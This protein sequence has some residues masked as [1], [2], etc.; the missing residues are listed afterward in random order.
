[1]AETVKSSGGLFGLARRAWNE[2]A[3]I[4]RQKIWQISLEQD[5]GPRA[6]WYALLRV[7][8]ITLTGLG[9]I[10]IFSRAAA[11]SYSS[12]LGIGPMIAIAVMAAGTVLHETPTATIIEKINQGLR[13][14]AP[15][16]DQMSAGAEAAEQAEKTSQLAINQRLI[17]LL[18]TFVE[19]SR[20]KAIGT[21]GL[22]M[23]IV[24]VVQLFISIEESFNTIW[25]VR[26]GRSM[27]TRIVMYWTL[28]TLGAV[29]ALVAF[30]IVSSAITPPV[31]DDKA[32]V[33]PSTLTGAQPDATT[34][35]SAPVGATPRSEPK[36]ATPARPAISP[37][38]NPA[39]DVKENSDA[40]NT[41]ALK[42]V[43]PSILFLVLVGLLTFFYRFIPNTNVR[44]FPSLI[45]AAVVA[46]LL[47]ANNYL[48][49]FYVRGVL[50]AQSLFGSL[51]LPVVLMGGL[52]IFWL[53]VLLGGQITYAVQNVHY[54]SSRT[55]WEE[56]NQHSREGLSLLVLVLI[57]RR[58]K[59]T[60]APFT[61][62][63]LSTSMRVPAQVLNESINRLVDLGYVSTIPPTT[64][65]GSQDYRYQPARPLDQITLREFRDR[66]ARLGS[67]PSGERLD[68][69][70]P[71]L[72]SF[73]E[74]VNQG[75]S[76]ALGDQNLDRA[77]D[78]LPVET[79]LPRDA[80]VARK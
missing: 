10:K 50:R 66:F 60:E 46:V 42:W 20:S 4:Y 31:S 19:G 68:S 73:H 25:G 80:V 26:R 6:R 27:F 56:L 52:Y 74:R 48:A 59:R 24:I 15:Q 43:V 12:L 57:A 78:E 9:E 28:V 58:F 18:N 1:M 63:Q 62:S 67:S 14:I 16:L 75:I 37:T 41:K 33:G 79:V 38:E 71:I 7:I 69:V 45:G 51:A 8:S 77:I 44:W 22:L 65:E 13:Y 64:H 34:P 21:A 11:L 70:D 49:F 17:D 39:T 61:A 72:R 47:V 32:A 55:A 54:R 3:T 30:S 76:E 40:A 2:L 23:L 29:L 36:P 5:H 35:K 53:F